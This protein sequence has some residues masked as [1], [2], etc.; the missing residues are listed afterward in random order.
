[1]KRLDLEGL[2]TRLEVHQTFLSEVVTYGDSR[3]F[4]GKHAPF[5]IRGLHHPAITPLVV[6]H[7]D[8]HNLRSGHHHQPHKRS[9]S[10]CEEFMTP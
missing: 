6:S 1:M 4:Q 5:S 7:L 10:L 2:K 3:K 9:L 8:W